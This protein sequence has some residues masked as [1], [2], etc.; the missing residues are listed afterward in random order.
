LLMNQLFPKVVHSV[1]GQFQKTY[2]FA[3]GLRV[4]ALGTVF[5]ATF[6]AT[7]FGATGIS[8]VGLA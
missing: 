2:H 3:F 1:Q 4:V 7:G 6:L 8:K 5:L